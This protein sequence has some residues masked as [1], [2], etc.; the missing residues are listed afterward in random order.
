MYIIK[1]DN[2]IVTYYT[3]YKLFIIPGLAVLQGRVASVPSDTQFLQTRPVPVPMHWVETVQWRRWLPVRSV[4]V[5]VCRRPSAYC[6]HRP[7]PTTAHYSALSSVMLCIADR[8][9]CTVRRLSRS[10][11]CGCAAL[12]S[13]APSNTHTHRTVK[14]S[15]DVKNYLGVQKWQ[16]SLCMHYKSCCKESL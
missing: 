9:P 4:V 14:V 13:L 6:S 16:L 7:L 8:S 3:V 5:Q 12:V 10:R 15:K 11:E 1:C 2:T